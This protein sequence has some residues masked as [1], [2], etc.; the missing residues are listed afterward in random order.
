LKA[1]DRFTKAK[2][3]ATVP[4]EAAPKLQVASKNI[5]SI[6]TTASSAPKL[7]KSV[8]FNASTL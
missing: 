3:A 4:A 7:A 2:E 6:N 8:L 1:G 5:G